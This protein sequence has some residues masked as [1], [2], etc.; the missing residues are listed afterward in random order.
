MTALYKIVGPNGEPRNG[1]YGDW[2]LPSDSEPGEWRTVDGD[3]VPCRNGLHL[4][5]AE[6][7]HMWTTPGSMVYRA[8]VAGPIVHADCKYVAGKVRL[9]P[10]PIAA[11]AIRDVLEPF[12]PSERVPHARNTRE[13]WLMDNG[14]SLPAGHP[15]RARYDALMGAYTRRVDRAR[16][17]YDK[18]RAS[19]RKAIARWFGGDAPLVMRGSYD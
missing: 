10:G 12:R 1:G 15:L 16:A 3:L 8:E 11:D 17:R 2:P 9:V 18:S 6:H 13:A 19:A 14:A 7:L 5:D 4:T